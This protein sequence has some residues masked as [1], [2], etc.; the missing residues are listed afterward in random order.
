MGEDK[1]AHFLQG[2]G[3]LLPNSFQ[4]DIIEIN[5]QIWKVCRSNNH[6]SKG[7]LQENSLQTGIAKLGFT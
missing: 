6:K 5:F 4:L 7:T 2:L 1:V 3:W